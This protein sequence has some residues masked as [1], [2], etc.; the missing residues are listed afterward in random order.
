MIFTPSTTSSL[1]SHIFTGMPNRSPSACVCAATASGARISTD[2][3]VCRY[4]SYAQDNCISVL[5]SP[6]SANM[7]ARPFASAHLTI[8]RWK[9]NRFGLS[10][11]ADI[12]NPWL[13]LGLAF[14]AI[15]S[16]YFI[17]RL[18]CGIIPLK[19]FYILGRS[20][21]PLRAVFFCSRHSSGMQ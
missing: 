7:A 5:P 11:L 16:L 19:C 1:D 2:P 8:S 21:L 14:A 12:V 4:T 9:S 20:Q 10:A 3:P 13:S 17:I 18:L 15:N 6:Q